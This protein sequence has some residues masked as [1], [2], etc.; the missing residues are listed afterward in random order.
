MR[1][2]IVGNFGLTGKQTMAMRALPL[3]EALAARGHAVC[4]ALPI[5]QHGDEG[6]PRE[7]NGVRIDYAGRGPRL[8]LLTQLWQLLWL[9]HHCW[10]FH[11]D[12]LYC[13]KPIAYSGATLSL[14][15]LLRRLGLFR[16]TL[17]L[18]TDD[19]E[20][21]GGW[22][23]KQ[24][25]PRWLKGL[26][27][28]QELWSLRHA[29]AVTVASR[30]LEKMAAQAGA[31]RV[32]YLPNAVS[33]GSP[34]LLDLDDHSAA[35]EALAVAIASPLPLPLAA[36]AHHG[37]AVVLAYTRFVEFHPGRLLDSFAG[38]L[39]QVD[40]AL[41]LV[42]GQGLEGEERDLERLAAERGIVERVVL[43]GWVS[44]ERLPGYLRAADLALY[45]MDDTVLNRTKC[46]MKLVELLAAGV[47]VVADRVGQ[48]NEYVEDGRTGVLVPPGDSRAMAAAAAALLR[49]PARRRALADAARAETHARWNWSVWAPEVERALGA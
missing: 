38:I 5:R 6:G 13:F 26:I 1:I 11:P 40:D 39:D 24:P 46:P 9:A 16:G 30:A 47:P 29:E 27:A 7:R 36:R 15:W 10:H 8:P 35:G 19:W 44:P 4:L 25:W 42:V 22:N 31:R 41:L 23:E 14:F 12:A 37:G 49:D 34:A 2:A 3:A 18:D 33:P 17:L 32:V 48:A 21:Y 43:A 20:G 28:R 45:L